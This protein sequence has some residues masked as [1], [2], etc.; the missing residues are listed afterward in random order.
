MAYENKSDDLLNEIPAKTIVRRALAFDAARHL[1][2][3]GRYFECMARP[4]RWA[5]WKYHAV[6]VGMKLIKLY[7]PNA[8]W[9]SYPIASAHLI[10]SALHQKSGIPWIAD[11]RDPM[12]HEGYPVDP[13]KWQIYRDIETDAV[14]RAQRCIFTTPSALKYYKQRYPDAARRMGVI[15]NGY[16]EES[17]SA[18]PRAGMRRTDE[19]SKTRKIVILHSGIIYPTERNPTQLFRALGQL[20]RSGLIQ[21]DVLCIRF[22]AAI[23]DALLNHLAQVNGVQD[24]VELCTPIP[25]RDALAEMMEVDALLVM[26]GRDCNAQIPA[27]IYEYIRAGK[28]ILGLT[29]QQGDTACVLKEAGLNAIASLDSVCEIASVLVQFVSALTLGSASLPKPDYVA[30]ASRRH[31]TQT[32]VHVLNDLA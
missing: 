32:L 24:M 15:E 29:D 20:K 8:I 1:Q 22:R 27:K 26:Q 10:A 16:D 4:D 13:Q 3:K 11:F 17:F 28:P 12:A 9:S 7:K 6:L 18:L 19:I 21:P 25:Y 14:T 5:S 31:R 30:S 23:H 2:Y